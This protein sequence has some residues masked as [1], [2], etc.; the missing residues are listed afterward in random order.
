MIGV[1]GID[2]T[3]DEKQKIK[4]IEKIKMVMTRGKDDPDELYNKLGTKEYKKE[5][6]RLFKT[7]KSNFKIA[8]VV[9]MWLTGFDVPAL[10]TIYIDKPVQK[11]SLIQTIS[12]VNRRYEGKERGLVVDYIGIKE[13]MLK[14]LEEYGGDD[15][16]SGGAGPQIEDI[17]KSVIIVKD[18]LDLLN[19]MFHKVDTTNYFEGTPMQQL[20]CLNKSVEFVMTTDKQ[21]KWFMYT[22][23]RL[24]LAYDIACSSEKFS[25]LERDFIHFYLAVRTLI[26][27]LTKGG[28]PDIAT[29]NAKV[30]QMI[31]DALKSNEV[32]EIIKMCEKD[33]VFDIF[34]DKYMECICKMEEPNTKMKLLMKLL[35]KAIDDFSKSNKYKAIE[36]TKAFNH[37]VEKYNNREELE[38]QQD[39]IMNDFTDEI[40]DLMH[41][42]KEETNSFKGMDIDFE[43]KVFYDILKALAEKYEFEYPDEKLI[44]LSKKVKRVIADKTRYT[45]WSKKE[46]IKAELKVD[47]ILL[48]AEYSYPPVD[49]DEVY[50]EVFEQAKNFKKY[51]PV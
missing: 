47:L 32:V 12:R 20:H 49:R 40:I 10:D 43:E 19:T 36:F 22:V 25:Q 44:A 48:L 39:N 4:P 27:K 5:L 45:D 21:E 37:V 17:E 29:M 14:A 23:R 38:A 28:S 35:K 42:L 24:K 26:F 1:E 7:E 51:K 15:G 18:F 3:D 31:E 6:D 50:S 13:Q 8:I 41:A 34:D 16:G 11:H 46:D 9:D 30:Q 2:L 33:G